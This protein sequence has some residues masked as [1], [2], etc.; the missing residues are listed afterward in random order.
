MLFLLLILLLCTVLVPLREKKKTLTVLT[1]YSVI[2]KN[3]FGLK[4]A[5]SCYKA[6]V[7][8]DIKRVFITQKRS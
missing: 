3:N 2:L 7:C 4:E 8:V 5:S 1:F 6:N